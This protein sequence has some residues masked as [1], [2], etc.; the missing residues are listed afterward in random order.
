M[1]KLLPID[2]SGQQKTPHNAEEIHISRPKK[3][4]SLSAKPRRDERDSGG[5]IA[6]RACLVIQAALPH[7]N[8]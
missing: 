4:E 8:H 5:M 2:M 1:M 7:P 3:S 6:E